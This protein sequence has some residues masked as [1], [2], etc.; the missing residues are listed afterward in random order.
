MTQVTHPS[1]ESVRELMARHREEKTP[2]LSLEE[3]RRRLGWGLVE[4]NKEV[5][6]DEL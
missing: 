6:N 3:I 2:P 4:H 5:T 1:K